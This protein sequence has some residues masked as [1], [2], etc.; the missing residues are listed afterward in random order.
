MIFTSWNL[1]KAQ[2]KQVVLSCPPEKTTNARELS[3]KL[4]PYQGLKQV[5]DVNP[6]RQAELTV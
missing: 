3:S 5:I 4:I 1:L 6:G 2:N